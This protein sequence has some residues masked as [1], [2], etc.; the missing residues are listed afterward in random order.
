[1]P[2]HEIMNTSVLG[3]YNNGKAR[4]SLDMREAESKGTTS[5]QM[6]TK[7]RDKKKKTHTHTLAST[8]KS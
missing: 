7:A 3:K 2:L 1:M 5:E 6:T 4:I 8:G